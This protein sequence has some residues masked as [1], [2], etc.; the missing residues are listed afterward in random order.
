MRAE[1]GGD[2]DDPDMNLIKDATLGWGRVA[3]GKLDTVE[4]KGGHST[5]LQEPHVANLARQI[6]GFLASPDSGQH[7]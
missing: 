1:E 2:P 3:Q 7:R 4:V 6:S 5:M